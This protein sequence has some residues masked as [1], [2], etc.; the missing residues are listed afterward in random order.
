MYGWP[1]HVN[2]DDDWT[3][4]LRYD[5]K[6]VL[7]ILILNMAKVGFTAP[8]AEYLAGFTGLPACW[9]YYVAENYLMGSLTAGPTQLY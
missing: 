6:P 1:K 3:E 8:T 9:V 5:R 4:W 7:Y 2:H